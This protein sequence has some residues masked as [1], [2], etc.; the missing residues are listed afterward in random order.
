MSPGDGGG[1]SWKDRL[2]KGGR[3]IFHRRTAGA[4]ALCLTIAAP[5][6]AQFPKFSIPIIASTGGMLHT[7]TTDRWSGALRVAPSLRLGADRQH[8]LGVEALLIHQAERSV[9]TGGITGALALVHFKDAGILAEFSATAGRQSV[10]LSIGLRGDL[11]LALLGYLQVAVTAGWDAHRKVADAR[12]GVG[13]D[14]FRFFWS[15]PGIPPP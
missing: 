9:L 1:V 14:L 6:R 7:P 2:H 12:I 3:M 4:I 5:V 11:P 13:V 8:R 15:E 10:P